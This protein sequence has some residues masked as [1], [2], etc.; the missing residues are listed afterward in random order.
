MELKVESHFHQNSQDSDYS[1]EEF[2]HTE[3]LP[4]IHRNSN[5]KLQKDPVSHVK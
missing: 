1:D 5:I 2:V 4:L 3:K